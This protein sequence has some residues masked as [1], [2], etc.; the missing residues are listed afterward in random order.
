MCKKEEFAT[1]FRS[2]VHVV[3][4]GHR[5]SSGKIDA[6]PL[7]NENEQETNLFRAVGINFS[8]DGLYTRRIHS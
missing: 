5:P 3:L 8:P 7:I 1:F 2:L 4:G 6:F